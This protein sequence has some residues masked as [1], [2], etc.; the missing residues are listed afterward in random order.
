MP[1]R[2]VANGN[3]AAW[4]EAIIGSESGGLRLTDVRVNVGDTVKAGDVLAVFAA[5]A[6]QADM[7]QATAALMEAEAAAADAANN[8]ARARTLKDSGALSTQQIN[9]F[10]TGAQTA[11][12]RVEAARAAVATQQ[13]RLRYTRV[14]AP[15]DGI[16]SARTA[17][18]GAVVPAGAELFR[19][20]RQ[21]RLEWRA[22]VTAT[23]LGSIRP[24]AAA[25][26]AAPGGASITGRVRMIAPTVDAQTPHR[27]GLCRPAAAR[28][29]RAAGASAGMLRGGEFD[30][31]SAPA[32]T[33]PQQA[34]VVRDGFSYVFRLNPDN[35]VSQVK[36][37]T[38]RR[39]GERWS[40]S[41]ASRLTRCWRWTAPASSTTATWCAAPTPRPP[42]PARRPPPPARAEA[43][44]DTRELFRPVD[45]QPD[46]GHHAV[47]AADAGRPAGLP[48]H[49][50]QDFPDIELPVVTVSP[51]SPGAAPAQLE[52]EVAR[53]IEDCVATLQGVKNIYTRVLDGVATIT[54]EFILEKPLAEAVNDVRDAVARVRADLPADLREPSRDQGVHRRPRGADL[55][56]CRRARRARRQPHGHAGTELVRRQYCRQ[57]PAGRAR[58]RRGQA[59]GRRHPR[60]PGRTRR[61]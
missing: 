24:G 40:W 41:R 30:L 10:T 16:I 15:D 11:Q 26:V 38:G 43:P 36:V 20:I 21:G 48:G 14:L 60:S 54:V 35:R 49:A 59:H 8:A 29:R 18:V 58:R 47:R 53:K 33:V 28:V 46:P 1:R 6:V 7:A 25:T 27:A 56:R 31:G 19:M 57:A 42:P 45:P 4:Q 22:E 3:V 9:Q 55:H 50:V 51:R 32:L 13:L 34:V 23:E 61:R 17:T 2:L 44:G 52:T 37:R 39:L 12:A 5:D